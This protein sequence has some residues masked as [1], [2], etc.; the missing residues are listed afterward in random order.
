MGYTK[1][2]VERGENTNPVTQQGINL[3]ANEG[4]IAMR[5]VIVIRV[6]VVGGATAIALL[7]AR[8]MIG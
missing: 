2:M 1:N 3:A 7:I 4:G 8:Y 5:I 6:T